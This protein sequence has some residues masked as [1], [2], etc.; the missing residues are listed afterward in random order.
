MPYSDRYYKRF[1]DISWPKPCVQASQEIPE[2]AA[3]SASDRLQ[4]ENRLRIAK[5]PG[6]SLFFT[7]TLI[8]H[9]QVALTKAAFP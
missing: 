4:T 7:L 6:E 2:A 5:N 9:I 8:G 3:A 1:Q